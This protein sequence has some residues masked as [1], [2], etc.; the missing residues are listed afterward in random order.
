VLRFDLAP[1]TYL[2]LLEPRDAEELHALMV[3]NR[4]HLSPWM[5]WAASQG[6]AETRVFIDPTRRQIA[7][8]AGFQTAIVQDP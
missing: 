7:D 4:A 1:G 5:P 2:R 3:A 8:D 6:I